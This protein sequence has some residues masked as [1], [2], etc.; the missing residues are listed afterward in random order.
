MATLD[1]TGGAERQS[2]ERPGIHVVVLILVS[3]DILSVLKEEML[4]EIDGL[5]SNDGLRA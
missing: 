5:A 2:L 1:V 4:A 3:L